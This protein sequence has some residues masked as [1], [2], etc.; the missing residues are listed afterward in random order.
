MADQLIKGLE[1]VIVAQTS[2][3]KIDGQN[4]RLFYRGIS[5]EEFIE[6][7]LIPREAEFASKDFS[8]LVP[9]LEDLRNM[10]RRMELWAPRPPRRIP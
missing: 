5:I 7:E 3:S 6:K 8:E 10:V 4:G 1:G 2:S 9:E